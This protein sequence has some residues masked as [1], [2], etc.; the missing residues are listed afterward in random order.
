MV[1]HYQA[2]RLRYYSDQPTAI[3]DVLI[4][5]AAAQKFCGHAR[6]AGRLPW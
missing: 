1:L 3:A 4:T 5:S 6:D 2:E